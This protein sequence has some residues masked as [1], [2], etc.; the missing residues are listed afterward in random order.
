MIERKKEEQLMCLFNILF[1]QQN[2]SGLCPDMVL[3]VKHLIFVHI[4]HQILVVKDL[5]N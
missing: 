2:Q 1:I 3:E 5:K 4:C